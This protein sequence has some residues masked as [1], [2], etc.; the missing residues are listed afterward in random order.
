MTTIRLAGISGSLRKD[1]NNTAILKTLQ[2]RLPAEIEL[3]L[4]RK[5]TRLNSNHVD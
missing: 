1:S 3:S 4:D 5:S 2:E